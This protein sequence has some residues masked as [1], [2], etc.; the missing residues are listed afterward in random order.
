MKATESC[1]LHSPHLKIR[2]NAKFGAN[3]ARFRNQSPKPSTVY[4][5]RNFHAKILPQ[6]CGTWPEYVISMHGSLKFIEMSSKNKVIDWRQRRT[7]LSFGNWT[8]H[9]ACQR[10]KALRTSYGI[11]INNMSG[12]NLFSLLKINGAKAACYKIFST[13]VLWF[14]KSRFLGSVFRHSKPL[15]TGFFGTCELI[16]LQPDFCDHA[17][18]SGTACLHFR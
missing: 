2:K 9:T 18:N 16:G 8:N 13:L 4:F 3:S 7:I 17:N 10:A 14:R 12:A 5:K 15:L 6:N 11:E 1:L